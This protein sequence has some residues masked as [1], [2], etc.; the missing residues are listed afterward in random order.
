L[1]TEQDIQTDINNFGVSNATCEL[2]RFSAETK[3]VT[4]NRTVYVETVDN[5]PDLRFKTVDPG[6]IFF[7]QSIGV[8]VIAGDT[9]WSA[10]N[11][12]IL[13]TDLL[14]YILTWG[15]NGSGRLGDNTTTT[16]SSPVSVVGGFTDW[17]QVSAGYAHSLG[18][19][20][21]G[22]AWAW[23]SNANGRLG[24]NTSIDR[25]SPVSVVGGFTDWCQ[26]SAGGAHTAALRT[27]GTA[28]TWG[29]NFRGQLG[30]NTSI[31]RSSPVSVVG[32]FTDWC[33]ISAG[34]SHTAAI[35]TNGTAWAWGC[36][37]EGRLGDDSTTSRSSPVSVVGGFTDW[38]QISAGTQHT[39]AI[40]NNGTA[41]TWGHNC[42]GQLGDNSS[43]DR[44]SPVSV[45]GGFTD[46]CQISVGNAG[47]C[48]TTALRTN[49]TTWAWGCN[50][51]GQL[52][53]NT[54]TSRSSPVSV[55]GG[56]TDWCQISTGTSHTS[57][58]RTNGTTWAWGSNFDGQL[59]DNTT[60]LRSSPVLVVV[61]I[62][63]WCQIS[64]GHTHTAAIR[65]IF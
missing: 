45:V 20:T 47:S 29:D 35:R 39:A 48:H 17:C 9:T 31:D 7:V 5:L 1:R 60:T 3:S 8:P 4:N 49:G 62:T 53:D 2:V 65:N 21:N 36:N 55:V 11:N 34:N 15:S 19:R 37:G 28:W 40:R 56:F 50:Y 22:T 63:D 6:T 51:N 23:G 24:D 26:V 42:R 59:G 43:I 25:S 52:G 33:Q 64:A 27:N 44:S 38:C 41:W 16:R 18:V 54:T 10:L 13:R 57:A 58:I 46:W 61:G 12:F 14:K 32:G 30:D